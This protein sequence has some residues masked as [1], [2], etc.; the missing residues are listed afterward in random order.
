MKQKFSARTILSS[1]NR[2]WLKAK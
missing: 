1:T 2:I